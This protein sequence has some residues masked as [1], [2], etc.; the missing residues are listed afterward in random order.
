MAAL[1]ARHDAWMSITPFEIES[2]EIGIRLAHG[3]VLIFG[4]GMGWAA[5]ACAALPAVTRGDGGREGSGSARAATP[6]DI[7]AQLPMR[8]APSSG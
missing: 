8:P 2:Q 3:H 4:L 6:L 1:F 5:A 7:F